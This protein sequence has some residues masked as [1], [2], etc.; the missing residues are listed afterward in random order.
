VLRFCRLCQTIMSNQNHHLVM[1]AYGTMVPL[2]EFA[3]DEASSGDDR[4]TK[5]PK[6]EEK[7]HDKGSVPFEQ[8]LGSFK[9]SLRYLKRAVRT[10]QKHLDC[11]ESI[12]KR[13]KLHDE[14]NQRARRHALEARARNGD[15]S[16]TSSRAPGKSSSNAGTHKP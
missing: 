6:L 14:E 13:Q 12:W 8:F 1:Q 5:K 16:A 2:H 3:D 10:H 9:T 11:L 4:P 15:V 7:E